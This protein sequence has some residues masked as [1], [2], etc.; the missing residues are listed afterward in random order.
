MRPGLIWGQTRTS[1][2]GAALPLPASAAADGGCWD[3]RGPPAGPRLARKEKTGE[4]NPARLRCR[5]RKRA[6]RRRLRLCFDGDA[7]HTSRTCIAA[8][9]HVDAV[10]VRLR[11][12]TFLAL[13]E[14]HKPL[15]DPAEA[16]LALHPP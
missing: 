6:L 1:S 7:K 10:S 3:H 9:E 14:S 13:L 15:P 2:L 11:N 12:Q 16:L 5:G 8:S 4:E